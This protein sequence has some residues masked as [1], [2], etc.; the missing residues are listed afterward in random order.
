MSGPAPWTWQMEVNMSLYSQGCISVQHVHQKSQ[1][2]LWKRA[3]WSGKARA[4]YDLL[5]PREVPDAH[6]WVLGTCK[7]NG[8]LQLYVSYDLGI[9]LSHTD[10]LQFLYFCSQA[11]MFRLLS[12]YKYEA[13]PSLQKCSCTEGSTVGSSVGRRWDH[14]FV[15]FINGLINDEL[16]AG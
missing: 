16:I 1:A 12:W 6:P 13:H 11:N 2:E 8:R 10:S 9:R 7:I 14:N 4:E 15:N 3:G 5:D